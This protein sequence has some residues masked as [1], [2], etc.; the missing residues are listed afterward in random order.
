MVSL[1]ET[2]TGRQI[3]AAMEQELAAALDAGIQ[4]AIAEGY[5]E[6][7]IE[8]GL[9]AYMAVLSAGRNRSSS[10]RSRRCSWL[11]GRW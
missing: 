1:V 5:S 2:Q 4:E 7:A 3:D 9:A 10:S 6:A 8:A 11:C